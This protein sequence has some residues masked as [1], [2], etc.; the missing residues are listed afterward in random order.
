[1]LAELP[2]A[3]HTI[4]AKLVNHNLKFSLGLARRYR[5]SDNEQIRDAIAQDRARSRVQ[6]STARPTPPGNTRSG[7]LVRETQ[8]TGSHQNP[9]D[10]VLLRTTRAPY[11]RATDG[12]TLPIMT[13][14]SG[15]PATRLLSQRTSDV[16]HGRMRHLQQLTGTNRCAREP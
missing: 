3:P 7:R 4:S 8:G 5:R 13:L 16:Q 1:M 14:R 15:Q 10:E 12:V 11:L 9:V 6:A 2:G